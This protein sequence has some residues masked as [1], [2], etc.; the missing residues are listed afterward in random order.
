M[1][2]ELIE[3]IKELYPNPTCELKFGSPFQLLV[4]VVLSAQ[5]TDKRVNMVTE[6]LFKVASTPQHFVDMPL[7]EL[8]QRIHS[9]GFFHNK[10]L[11]IKGASQV[12]IERFGGNVPSSMKDL[13]S[14]PGVGV[15]TASVVQ[16]IAFRIPALAVDTHVFRVSN[17]LGVAQ[18]KNV[19]QM[20]KKLLKAV[21]K[22]FWIDYH[23]SIVLHG[24]YVCKA[25]KPACG[26]CGLKDFCKYYKEK[27]K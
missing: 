6:Q 25:Q 3:K 9:C 24:R 7:L 8:E 16:S 12:I 17:R 21:P 2:Q 26:E 23:Y 14:L 22:D 20:H 5:C 18:A 15:K 10:A 27:V 1:K 4:A 11:A 19:D 13:T